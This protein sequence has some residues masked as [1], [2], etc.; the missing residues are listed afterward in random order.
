[1]YEQI[2]VPLDGSQFAE[3]ALPPALEIARRAGGQVRLMTVCDTG[4]AVPEVVESAPSSA[5]G[6]EAY[7]SKLRERVGAGG[8]V[9]IDAEV[10][11]GPVVESIRDEV[12]RTVAGL[13]VLSTHGRGPLSRI[14][15][16]SV[17]DRLVRRAPCPLL[18]VRP[19][20]EEGAPDPWEGFP[21]DRI[22]V[23]LDGSR[24]GE[25]VLERA[26]GLGALFDAAFTLLTVVW[27]PEYVG[28]P[29]LP[30][31]AWVD[32]KKVLERMA[33]RA[34]ERLDEVAGRMRD[35][36]LRVEVAVAEDAHP[37]DAILRFAES[38]DADVVARGTLGRGGVARTVLGSV[39]DKVVR[40]SSTPLLL[41]RAPDE[42]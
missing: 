9:E 22:L 37:A 35:R 27:L 25:A 42:S 40:S 6:A 32:R 23:P 24:V 8:E 5:A 14:W 26:V 10:L 13:V 30:H 4:S 34:R 39:A 41:M 17:A 7:L 36:E 28:T 11:S 3:H 1:M 2:V 15:M 20:G 18:L 31:V 19:S 29:D 38:E 21:V 16:G 12:R 33:G